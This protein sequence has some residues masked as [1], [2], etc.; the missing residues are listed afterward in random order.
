MSKGEFQFLRE[1]IY[2]LRSKRTTVKN[3]KLI[4]ATLFLFLMLSSCSA[5]P[6][7]WEF[8][9]P[10]D[11]F[12][13]EALMDLHFLN[14]ST[15][16]EHGFIR[17][18]AD[19][20][21][22]VRG[23]GEAIR[24]WPVNGGS[25]SMHMSDEELGGHAR[26]LAKMGVNMNRFHGSICP[27]GKGTD[28]FDVDTAEVQAIWRWVAAM[29][30][31]G[32]YATISPFWAGNYHMGGWV[33][34][35]WGLEGYS[36]TDALWAVMYFNPRLQAAYKRWVTYLYTE[37]NPYTGLALKDDPA[38]GLIQIKN[39]DGVFWWSIADARPELKAMICS[40][41]S[42]W[43]KTEY[44]SLD[45]AYERWDATELPG[46]RRSEGLVD[47][48]HIYDLTMPAVGGKQKR[49]SDQ[50][51]FLASVQRAFYKEMYD[52]YRE[53]LGCRQLINPNNW[54]AADPARLGDLERWTYMAC[55]VPAVNRYYDPGHSGE[56]AGWRIDPGHHY[57]GLSALHR[58][59]KLPFNVKQVAGAPMIITESGWNLPNKHQSEAPALV[60]A[61][62]GLT[63]QD[64]FY[65]FSIEAPNYMEKPYFDF[66]KHGEGMFAMH[67]WTWST[68]GGIA[69]FPAYALA[70]RMGY[71]EKGET[72]VRENRSMEELW[73]RDLPVISEEGSFDPNHAG[74]QT[75]SVTSGGTLSPL[76]FLCGP[77]EV[78]YELDDED[79][80]YEGLGELLDEEAGKIKSITGQLELDYRQGLFTFNTPCAAGFSGFP[81]ADHLY[82][83]G[84]L[85]IYSANEYITLG[86]V[87]MDGKPL[88]ESRE[89]LLQSGTSYRPS[90]WEEEAAVYT[91]K[92]DS[93]E[94]FLI[95][96]T[97]RMPW[98]ADATRAEIRL[99]NTEI[100][101]AFLL[102][103][104][105]YVTRELPIKRK[106]QELR[107]ELPAEALYVVLRA[108]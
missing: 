99:K 41:F 81:L 80:I 34:E 60:A 104:A 5:Q 72:V 29:K 83:L 65:W 4:S 13:E 3:Q 22:F 97:G 61:Y 7:T 91:L 38:V 105:G 106:K 40:R 58:P 89:I 88:A 12:T 36:G 1:N 15:A 45:R 21:S 74:P 33:P 69:Q 66:V 68:P 101:R 31:E 11:D 16:G 50:V 92:N 100:K 93:V 43:L 70:H 108:D 86:A 24:F 77:V 63:G 35:E 71:F 82:Q 2:L 19:G 98:L 49:L 14:E 32:I 67:R 76:V 57:Q 107:L 51:R 6:E 10:G 23:D 79:Y 39:E 18:S 48:Y 52:F 9:Y 27:P 85:A 30:K 42:E 20:S 90:G 47:I 56:N 62:Q 37:I 8:H 54:R 102:D 73:N 28:I 17:L 44:G 64:G 59:E 84:P 78:G 96:D 103:A 94:G 25:A 55:E 26:F 53:D 95:K 87:S 46:D 75:T